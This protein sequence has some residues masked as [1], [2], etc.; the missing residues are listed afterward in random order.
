MTSNVPSLPAAP[1]L[2]I[3]GIDFKK[4]RA[5]REMVVALYGSVVCMLASIRL[6]VV[7]EAKVWLLSSLLF[8]L[9]VAYGWW[10]LNQFAALFC[11]EGALRGNLVDERQT[12]LRNRAFYRSY[13]CVCALVSLFLMSSFLGRSEVRLHLWF[14][15]TAGDF[16]LVFW[17]FFVLTV[18]LPHALLAWWEQDL[19]DE[20]Q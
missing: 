18:T 2:R 14:P 4:Q 20:S 12:A 11:D 6:Y 1:S 5:R 15:R 3:M 19:L 9:M 13:Q 16:N 8:G 17:T 10:M 7:T